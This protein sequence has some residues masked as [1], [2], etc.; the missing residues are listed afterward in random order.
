MHYRL[1]S[2][3]QVNKVLYKYQFGFR[4]HY[5]TSLALI[6]VIVIDNIYS[7]INNDKFCGGVYLDLQK[8]FDTVNHDIFLYKLYHYGVR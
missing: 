1:Y 2:H 6:D 7:N 5:S 8:A 3:L 4:K